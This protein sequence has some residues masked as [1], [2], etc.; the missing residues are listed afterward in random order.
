MRG[1]RAAAGSKNT[2][3]IAPA[4][5]AAARELRN[6]GKKR[7]LL[8]NVTSGRVGRMGRWML[9]PESC[10]LGRNLNR[11]R[12][13]MA[14]SGPALP[15][16]GQFR[17]WFSRFGKNWAESPAYV[18]ETPGKNASNSRALLQQFCNSRARAA[19]CTAEAMWWACFGHG[20]GP[21]VRH[22]YPS[23]I[24]QGL[25]ACAAAKFASRLRNLREGA[26]RNRE[27]VQFQAAGADRLLFVQ[28]APALGEAAHFPRL[29][30]S[31]GLAITRPW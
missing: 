2:L 19:A 21:P 11:V 9:L 18:S 28:S 3:R 12:P 27:D 14:E 30:A 20:S 24:G 10:R 1:G 22:S 31:P 26:A 4:P 7:Q 5:Q 16:I 8:P 23:G 29:I 17:S 6:C 13:M 15:Q 25:A